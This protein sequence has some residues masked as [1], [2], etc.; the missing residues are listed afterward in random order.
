VLIGELLRQGHQV[1]GITVDYRLGGQAP[2]VARGPGF[3][4][5]VLPG[6][7]RAWRFNGWQPGRALDAFRVE[8]Q[9]LVATLA[10]LRPDV[11]HA[12]WTYEF[13][14]AALDSGLQ[15]ARR[16][17]RAAGAA[18]DAQ[19][20]PRAAAAHG[21]AGAVA[22]EVL[23]TVSDLAHELAPVPWPRRW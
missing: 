3:E 10:A 14:L 19:P 15:V 9:A 11:V 6:R 22:G 20:V 18:P 7:L 5:H 16:T 13:A 23:T 2:V 12:H 21:A 17:T 1:L 4:L 8:R